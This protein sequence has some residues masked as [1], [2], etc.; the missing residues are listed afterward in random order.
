M[1]VPV[2]FKNWSTCIGQSLSGAVFVIM[3]SF[4]FIVTGLS[5]AANENVQFSMALQKI[6]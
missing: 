5:R 2:N 6:E 4:F 3:H 1:Q